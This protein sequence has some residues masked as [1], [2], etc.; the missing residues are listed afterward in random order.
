MGTP[1]FL[2]A[3]PFSGNK[4]NLCPSLHLSDWVY[5]W[6]ACSGAMPCELCGELLPAYPLNKQ[7]YPQVARSYVENGHLGSD[8]QK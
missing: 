3:L 1:F 4:S 5:H 2:V 8:G 6:A 7:P